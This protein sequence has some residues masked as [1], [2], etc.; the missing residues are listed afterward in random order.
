MI[1]CA[2]CRWQF[3]GMCRWLPPVLMIDPSHSTTELVTVYP[4]IHPEWGCAQ[5]KP[6]PKAKPPKLKVVT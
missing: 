2:V 5:G 6:A 3:N 4:N 1:N